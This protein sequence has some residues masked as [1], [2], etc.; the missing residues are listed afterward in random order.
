MKL[1]YPLQNFLFSLKPDLPDTVLLLIIL[2]S[3][4]AFTFLLYHQL[5][6]SNYEL[7]LF[8]KKIS[9][10]TAAENRKYFLYLALIFF[11]TE[12]IYTYF[13]L[14]VTLKF[15]SGNFVAFYCICLYALT[16]F[17]KSIK[18]TNPLL[19]FSFA[20]FWSLVCFHGAFQKKVPVFE[21]SSKYQVN[22]T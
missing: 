7:S 4:F 20:V 14:N 12:F 2:A 8:N 15:Y 9:L 16:S 5:K 11:I 3:I 13:D 22:R 10:Q 1:F 17:K 19:I 21:M 6:V 18:F